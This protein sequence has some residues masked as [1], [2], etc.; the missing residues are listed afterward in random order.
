[1]NLEAGMS[2]RKTVVAL[3]VSPVAVML[4]VFLAWLGPRMI[5]ILYPRPDTF[6]PN[7][8]E[9]VARIRA[10][11]NLPEDGG[12]VWIEP[13]DIDPADYEKVLGLFRDSVVD[14]RR[15]VTHMNV[16]LVEIEYRDGRHCSVCLLKTFRGPAAYQ[17]KVDGRV[18][19]VLRG[20]TEEAIV[21]TI[22]ECR[23]RAVAVEK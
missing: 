8:P 16:G 15:G 14:T 11:L 13:F 22:R 20:S 5:N 18:G 7:G 9:S 1:L 12:G 19:S 10:S 3:L 17:L 4:L 21:R 6:P 2:G 23:E